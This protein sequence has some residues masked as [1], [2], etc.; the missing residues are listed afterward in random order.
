MARPL[1]E[2][3]RDAILTA[4]GKLV[5]VHGVAAS[6]AQI[7]KAAKVAEGTVFTYFETK[8]ALLNA[9][10]VKLEMR[11]ALTLGDAF[12]IEADAR[13]QLQYAWNALIQWGS[14]H[15]DD[16]KALRQLKVSDR[17]S[18]ATR[19][20]C[21]GLFGGM[22]Q[23]LQANLAAYI[24]PERLSFYLGRVFITLLET[25]LEAIAAQPEQRQTLQQAGF[26]LFWKGIQR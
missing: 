26:D 19:L 17:I 6:T 3:K 2:V 10:F 8:D 12:P 7:A 16:Q 1:S 13:T 24:D 21:E 5:A 25:T 18:D 9:L 20:H 15:P 11:L 22:M 14:R 4:A 23:S